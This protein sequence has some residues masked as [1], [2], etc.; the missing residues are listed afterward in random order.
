MII[1]TKHQYLQRE[2]PCLYTEI[3]K[4]VFKKYFKQSLIYCSPI[5]LADL[6][7]VTQL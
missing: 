3:C 6:I 5:I 2:D 1:V 7:R 4:L